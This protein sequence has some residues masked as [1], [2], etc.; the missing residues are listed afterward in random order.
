MG[1]YSPTTHPVKGLTVS[2]HFARHSLCDSRESRLARGKED[3]ECKHSKTQ[4]TRFWVVAS[5]SGTSSAFAPSFRTNNI[6]LEN[7]LFL[8]L[9]RKGI[10]KDYS[11]VRYYS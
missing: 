8:S 9:S 10:K 3:G 6:S 2:H 4:T 5:T 7:T 11:T 1:G